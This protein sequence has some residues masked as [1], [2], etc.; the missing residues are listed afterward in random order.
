MV[1]ESWC[2]GDEV[3]S[4]LEMCVADTARFRWGEV[5]INWIVDCKN[6]YM[7]RVTGNVS[8]EDLTFYAVGQSVAH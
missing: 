8:P 2:V 4:I 5:N 1:I 6:I 7:R 3:L